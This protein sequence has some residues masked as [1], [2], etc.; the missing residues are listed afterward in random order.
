MQE[1]SVGTF[2]VD[3][4]AALTVRL[5]GVS[6]KTIRLFSENN[7]VEWKNL[8]EYTMPQEYIYEEAA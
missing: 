1:G 6:S 7:S 3:G 2:Y 8:F 4:E 5:Y